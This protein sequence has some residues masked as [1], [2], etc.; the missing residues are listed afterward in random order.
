MFLLATH[1]STIAGLV[2]K[3]PI[4]TYESHFPQGRRTGGRALLG[5]SQTFPD[6]DASTAIPDGMITY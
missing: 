1:Y 3:I 2:L 4:T 5:H 6:V